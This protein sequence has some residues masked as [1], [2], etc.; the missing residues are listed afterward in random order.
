MINEKEDTF[1]HKIILA[2][3]KSLGSAIRLCFIFP[4]Y[5]RNLE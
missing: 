3:K 5:Y 2:V 4:I 1:Y